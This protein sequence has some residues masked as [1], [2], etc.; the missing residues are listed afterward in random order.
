[1]GLMSVSNGYKMISFCSSFRKIITINNLYKYKNYP[2]NILTKFSVQ[3]VHF[4]KNEYD[5]ISY[6]KK[7]LLVM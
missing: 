5:K 4:L 6:T 3:V 2:N 7:I 1:M